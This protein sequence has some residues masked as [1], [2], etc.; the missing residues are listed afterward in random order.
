MP[1]PV[2]WSR[3]ENGAVRFVMDDGTELLS[4]GAV[5]ERYRRDLPET[6]EEPRRDRDED[7]WAKVMGD[8]P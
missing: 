2:S 4:S 6:G 8:E 1:K 3:A 5:A 7:F